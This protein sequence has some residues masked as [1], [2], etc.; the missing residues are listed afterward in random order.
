MHDLTAEMGMEEGHA[1][2]WGFWGTLVWGMILMGVFVVLQVV[3]FG[4]IIGVTTG[5]VSATEAKELI[6]DLQ[7][8]GFALSVCTLVTTLGC[9]VILLGV[10]K[11]KKGAVVKKYLGVRTVAIK[12]AS[13]W[14]AAVLVCAAVSD[15]LTMVLGRPLVPEF[16]SMAY[17]SADPV[18]LF[19]VALVIAGPLFEEI[20][21]RGFLMEGFRSSF[22]GPIGAVVMT[23][24]SWA[25]I[26][27]QYDAY[28]MSTIF[29]LGCVLGAARLQ[30]GSV[31]L[32]IGMHALVNLIATIEAAVFHIH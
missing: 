23:S 3:A 22:L 18:W 9:G 10:I 16:L 21:F 17:S 11:L 14:M 27:L 25:A 7:Y 26:H 13:R 5:E 15:G 31:L 19:W 32:P 1:S 4:A 20:F 12:E 6:S 29:V 28:G 2:H 8:N 30:T 24:A